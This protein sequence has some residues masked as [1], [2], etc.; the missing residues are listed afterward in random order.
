MTRIKDIHLLAFYVQKPRAGVRNFEAGWNKNPENIQYD[1]RIEFTRGLSNKDRQYAGVILNLATK[2]VIYNKFGNQKTFD[3]LFKYFLEAYP[4]YVI[5]VM[6]QLDMPYLE[7]FIPKEEKELPESACTS[8]TV[9][10]T[11]QTQ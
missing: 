5:N 11:P 4:K 3:E 8:E 9:D 1:E 7:Q 10:E 2:K 6:A